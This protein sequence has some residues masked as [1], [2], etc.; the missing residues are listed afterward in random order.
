MNAPA[1]H[2]LTLTACCA[3]VMTAAA[4]TP[5]TTGTPPPAPAAAVR[6]ILPADAAFRA[7]EGRLRKQ[8]FVVTS[9]AAGPTSKLKPIL[10]DHLAYLATL[11][12]SGELFMAGPLMNE[13]PETWSGDGLLVYAAE[14]YQRAVEIADK[15]PLHASGARTYTI[16]PWLLNDGSLR[17]NIT[18]STQRST[19]P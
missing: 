8:L 13:D 2:T 16:R 9:T 11:E 12:R 7:S 19:L 5:L 6:D 14:S 18:L 17:L 1:S 10:P 15:D 4:F 3:V